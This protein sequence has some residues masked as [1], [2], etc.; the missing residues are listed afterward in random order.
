MGEQFVGDVHVRRDRALEP[1][2]SYY[3][4]DVKLALSQ[5][6][7]RSILLR[8]VLRPVTTLGSLPRMVHKLI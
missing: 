3:L 1:G 8:R 2:T 4:T 5:A 6:M 7:A